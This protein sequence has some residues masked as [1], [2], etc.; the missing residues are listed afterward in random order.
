MQNMSPS[1]QCV[2]WISNRN[3]RF[4]GCKRKKEAG[5]GRI[6]RTKQK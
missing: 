6:W 4:A 3:F 1:L 5:L 2:T